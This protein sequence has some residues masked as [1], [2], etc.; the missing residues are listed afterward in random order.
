LFPQE[1]GKQRS[2]ELG[3][4]PLTEQQMQ[5]IKEEFELD[6]KFRLGNRIGNI[7]QSYKGKGHIAIKTSQEREDLVRVGIV[8]ELLALDVEQKEL[9]SRLEEIKKL[10]RESANLTKGKNQSSIGE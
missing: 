4:L 5:Q 9:E 2:L 3:E 1:N 7:R 8:P 10:K 6:E